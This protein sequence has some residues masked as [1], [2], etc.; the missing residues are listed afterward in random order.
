M[1]VILAMLPCLMVMVAVLGLG[2]SGLAAA[3]LAAGT[4]I[5]LWLTGAFAL[6]EAAHIAHT[7]ADTAVLTCLVA[8]M[9]IPGILFVELASRKRAPEAITRVVAALALP[10]A[11]AAILIA[12]GVGVLVESLTGMGVSLLLTVPLLAAIAERR[13]AIG[14]ALVGMSLM[15]WGALSISAHLGAKLASLPIE[16]LAPAVWLQSGAIAF[17]LPLLCLAF[18]PRWTRQD[19]IMA[20]AAGL[21]LSTAI[22]LATIVVGIEVAG[23]TGGLSVIGLMIGYARKR[24]GL[25]P[26][27]TDAGLRPYLVLILAVVTQKL[28]VPALTLAGLAPIIATQRVSFN[29]L[30]SPG[31]ALLAAS[32]LIAVRGVS[33]DVIRVVAR[34]AWRPVLSI[35]LFMVTARLLVEIGAIAA[36]ARSISGLGAYAAV[37][38]IAALAA[39]SGFVTGS[40]VAG[41]ALFM[42]NAALAGGALGHLDIFVA[43]QN[44]VAGHSAI[45][46]L[47]IAA[48]LLAALPARGAGDD[49]AAMAI[50]LTL[51][52]VYLGIAIAIACLRLALAG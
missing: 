43:L 42:P 31:I 26:A 23:V 7:V 18:V 41:N 37:G 45:A 47:P 10:P 44:S 34:R 15:P 6:P 38:A 25:W 4:A 11:L 22:A 5:A 14:L 28:V 24:P 17:L 46:S 21:V 35:L 49:Q 50:G 33:A 12:T 39:V 19:L 13:A 40:G 27:L 3:S 51:A 36:L 16:T 20:L 2:W 29:V 32:L 8:A 52:L 30:T 9:I 48:I 1:P